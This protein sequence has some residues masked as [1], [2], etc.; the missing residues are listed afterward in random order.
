MLVLM[1]ALALPA[2]A[3]SNKGQPMPNAAFDLQTK[4][5]LTTNVGED[6]DRS[7]LRFAGEGSAEANADG[8][9]LTLGEMTQVEGGRIVTVTPEGEFTRRGRSRVFVGMGSAT[10][11]DNGEVT[12]FTEVRIMVKLQGRGDRLRLTG[13][14]RGKNGPQAHEGIDAPPEI[15]RGVIRGQRVLEDVPVQE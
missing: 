8:V 2:L 3:G 5:R 7:H 15:L 6:N 12:T 13:K 10:V 1:G 9:G 14:F 11:D 4:G